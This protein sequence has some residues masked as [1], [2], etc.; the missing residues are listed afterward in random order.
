M[1]QI[2][3]NGGNVAGQSQDVKSQF[4]M[5]SSNSQSS[6]ILLQFPVDVSVPRK[7]KF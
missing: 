3:N 7:I 6:Q 2:G 1:I 4:L 5:Q